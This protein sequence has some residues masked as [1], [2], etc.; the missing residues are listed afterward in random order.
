M[1]ASID[2][3]RKSKQDGGSRMRASY[4]KQA[5]AVETETR[6]EGEWAEVRCLECEGARAEQGKRV[7]QL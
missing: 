1:V 2:P 3:M 6:N 5:I 4:C 7:K